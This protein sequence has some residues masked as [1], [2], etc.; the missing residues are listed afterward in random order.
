MRRVLVVVLLLAT[1]CTTSKYAPLPE[2]K[3][4]KGEPTSSTTTPLDLEQVPL[5]GVRGT[6][7]TSNVVIG[8]GPVTIVGRVDGP[9][10]PIAGATVELVRWVGNR[11]AALRVPTATDGTWNATNLLGG[12]YRIRAWFAPLYGMDRGQTLFV[13]VGNPPSVNLRV[14]RVSG[15]TIDAAIAP[16]PAT[17]GQPANLGVRVATREVDS[18]GFIRSAPAV[19]VSVTLTGSGAWSTQSSNPSVTGS[20]GV[21]RFVVRCLAPGPQPLSATLSDGTSQPLDLGP[22][23]PA[24]ASTTSTSSSSTTS[25]TARST[26]TSRPTS[27]TR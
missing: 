16:D 26:S 8:P 24:P 9:D 10:G 23:S 17:V 14:D 2:P 3:S 11:F 27:T 4:S 12:E 5:A 13:A 19:G 6:T 15:T 18:G 1:A 21:A 25:T 7:T 20:E 22:C